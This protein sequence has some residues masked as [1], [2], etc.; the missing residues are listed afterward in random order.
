M[1]GGRMTGGIVRRG[2]RVYRPMGSWSPAVHEFLRH[3][4]S[5]RFGGAPR[6]LGVEDGREMQRAKLLEA[7]RVRYAPVGPAGAAMSLEYLAGQLR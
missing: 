7:E 4:D 6:V 2:D 5:A 3:L 1:T